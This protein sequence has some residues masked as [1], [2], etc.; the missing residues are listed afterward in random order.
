MVKK[1]LI[2]LVVLVA[3]GVAAGLVEKAASSSGKA[4]A[5]AGVGDKTRAPAGA[6][7]APGPNVLLVVVDTERADHT[8]AYGNA[9]PTTPF[10][11]KLAKE[12][13]RFTNA[14][15]AAPWTVPSMYS[16]FTG[17]YPSEHGITET[18]RRKNGNVDQP[19]LPEMATTLTERLK[20]QGYGTFG[21]N[22]N[23]HLSEKFGFAQGFDKFAGSWFLNLPFANSVIHHWKDDIRAARP[24]F[25][26]IHYFDPHFVYY[27]KHP[28]FDEWN[29]SPYASYEDCFGDAALDVLDKEETQTEADDLTPYDKTALIKKALQKLF[30]KLRKTKAVIKPNEI[31]GEGTLARMKDFLGAAYKSEIRVVDEALPAVFDDVGVDENMIVIYTADHGEELFE[32]DDFGHIGPNRH[33]YQELL[34]VPLVIVLP[35]REAA[36]KVVDTPVSLIDIIPTLMELTGTPVPADLPGRSLVPLIRGDKGAWPERALYAEVTHEDK[37]SRAIIRSPW[38]YIHDFATGMGELYDL[39]TDPGEKQDLSSAEPERAAA[40]RLDLLRWVDTTKPRW[41]PAK[42]I[43]LEQDDMDKLRALGYLL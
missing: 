8:S 31:M 18:M 23:L 1:A 41:A 12:G 32:H 39:A 33:L 16:L 28:W 21:V 3:I 26:W 7:H 35:G 13:V 6:K 4:G 43:R 36:G 20:A 22:T 27:L 19:V 24:R 37:T 30:D 34:N 2:V 5:H 14:F 42:P 9:E 10:L 11:E 40:M 29:K 25:V 38:K 15:S 17:V